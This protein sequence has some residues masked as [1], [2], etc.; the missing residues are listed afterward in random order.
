MKNRL[1]SSP[2]VAVAVSVLVCLTVAVG[3]ANAQSSQ[4]SIAGTVR[5]TSGAIMPGVTVEAA[6][7]ALIEKVRTAVTDN[8]GIYNIT[9]LR[10]GT[11]TVTFTLTGFNTVR[12]D[13]VELPASFSATINAELR[14]GALE[15]TITVSG[16]APTVDVRSATTQT[17]IPRDLVESL[18]VS[19]TSALAG[20]GPTI[21]GVVGGLGQQSVASTSMSIHGSRGGEANLT[22]DGYPVRVIFTMQAYYW[23]NQATIQD[24][25]V[26]T[27]GQSAE[28]QLGGIWMNSIPRDGGNQFS[29][30]LFGLYADH[31]MQSSNLTDELRAQ[32][33]TS[34]NRLDRQWEI[35]PALGGPVL[36]DKLWFYGAYQQNPVRTIIANNYF[37]KNPLAWKYEPDL[38]RPAYIQIR[39][40][41]REMRLTWQVTPRNKF[42]ISFDHTPH[43]TDQRSFNALVAPEAT[44]YA[45]Y[46]PM[47]FGTSTWRSPVTNRWLL[48]AGGSGQVSTIDNRRQFI[49]LDKEVGYDVIPARDANRGYFFR[50]AVIPGFAVPNCTC[51][52]YGNN[53]QNVF[54]GRL[55]TSYIS[56]SHSVKFGASL[57][58]GRYYPNTE[59]NGSMGVSLLNDAPTTLHLFATPYGTDQSVNADIGVFA[60]DQ[61]SIRRLTLNYGARFEY[62]HASAA[63]ADLPAGRFVPARHFDSKDNVPNWK[64]IV[65]RFGAAYD[66]FGDGKTA[67]KASL[68]KYVVFEAT[69]LAQA[70]H[71]VTR[72]VT[73]ATRAWNDANRDFAPDCDFKIPGANGECGPLSNLNFGQSNPNATTF[74]TAVTEGWGVRPYNWTGS[75]AL[76]R[77]ITNGV[78]VNVGYYRRW[79]GNFR[80]N[81]NTRVVPADFS[82]FCITAPTD[83]RLG[84]ASGKPMCGLYDVSAAKFGQSQSYTTAAGNFGEQTEVY[85]GVDVTTTVRAWGASILGG[86]STGRTK[87]N[88]CFVIDSPQA[89]RF[90]DVRPPFQPNIKFSG[91]YT[92]PW[93]DLQASFVYQNLP[94]PEISALYTARNVEIAPSLGRNL[95]SGAAGT[96]GVAL[97]EPGTEYGPRLSQTDF[98]LGKKFEIRRTQLMGTFQLFNIFNQAGVQTFNANYG[99]ATSNAAW[100]QPTLVLQGRQVQLTGQLSF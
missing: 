76:Q 35:A 72:S 38:S 73:S 29:G 51:V 82:T 18:P 22:I 36:R 28:T 13:A 27:E 95:S 97:I 23:P 80:V 17:I 5:D 3:S 91:S 45:P 44:S 98:R 11:Y 8:Q 47:W 77:Q 99:T 57:V 94:G 39:N 34:V 46:L 75:I 84:K 43:Y 56:G 24:V 41:S 49:G 67:L 81:D 100:R 6:S 78:A 60:Q 4:S 65:P 79:F 64:N 89:M 37:N 20:L 66:L 53:K 2:L 16:A 15:E 7:P 74:D 61:W 92:L 96:V 42:N 19:R 30:S 85:D 54:T 62:L 48:E 83:S 21:P 31:N 70:A 90:C 9:D 52:T 40:Y 55:A 69:G 63:A 14:V 68:G 26:Q 50:S 32:G 10:P 71:G 58:K 12:R 1:M 87:T 88:S 25:V 33:L 86:V 93:W 59:V